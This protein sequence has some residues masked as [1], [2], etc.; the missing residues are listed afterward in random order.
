M[1]AGPER[2]H[3]LG[4][5]E[6]AHASSDDGFTVPTNVVREAEARSE[7]NGIALVSFPLRPNWSHRHVADIEPIGIHQEASR[8]IFWCRDHV[9]EKVVTKPHIQRQPGMNTPVVLH[10]QSPFRQSRRVFS[11]AE[12]NVDIARNVS[13]KIR[14]TCVGPANGFDVGALAAVSRILSAELQRVLSEMFGELLA[15]DL[16]RS[17]QYDDL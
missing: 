15:Q 4:A 3:N 13:Q 6:Y 16:C 10:E 12:R 1:Y 9:A 17:L 11:L 7:V 8:C 14:Q 5:E 2:S